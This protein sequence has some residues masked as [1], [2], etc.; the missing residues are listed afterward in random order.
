MSLYYLQGSKTPGQTS[1]PPQNHPLGTA[2]P[3]GS[4]ARRLLLFTGSLLILAAAILQ[5][6]DSGRLWTLEHKLIGVFPAAW[7]PNLPKVHLLDMET[8]KQGFAPL[9]LAVALRGLG[10]LHPASVLIH[11]TIAPAPDN[12]P[13]PLLQGVLSRLREEGMEITIP[14]PPSPESLWHFLPLCCYEPP[15]AL[16]PKALWP[17]ALGKPSPSGKEYFLPNDAGSD[18]TLPLFATT[19][20]GSIIGSLW[21][22]S[23]ILSTPSSVVG[24]IWLLG[25]RLLILPNHAAI[26]LNEGGAIAGESLLP[27]I[28]SKMVPLA[29]FLL[30][31]EQKE[32]GTLSPGF[33]EIWE[34]AIVVIGTPADLPR[35]SLLASVQARLALRSLPMLLQA[36]LCILWIIFFVLGSRLTQKARISAALILMLLSVGLSLY[37][38]H[39]GWLL[40]WIPPLLAALLLLASIPIL[41][42]FPQRR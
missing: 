27:G 11:G 7:Q 14:L 40:P 2:T 1:P 3:T 30:K 9:D 20:E 15:A 35:V 19:E 28:D 32:R 17:T 18:S 21:W 6:V 25:K 39:A 16:R 42:I 41:K 10:K 36:A 26:L 13:I 38:L 12:E 33:D 22:K 8:E 5:A 34:N 37:A 29:D 24:P 31:L 4:R 23:L